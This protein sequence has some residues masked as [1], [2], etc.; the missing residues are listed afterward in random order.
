MLTCLCPWPAHIGE[1][2]GRLGWHIV[3]WVEGA[4]LRVWEAL[5][6][7]GRGEKGMARQRGGQAL[8]CPWLV[9][10]GVGA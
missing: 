5:Q 4:C 3:G 7:R 6:S 10:E 2:A 1:G 8:L 9:C